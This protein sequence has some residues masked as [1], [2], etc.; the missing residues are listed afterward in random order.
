MLTLPARPERLRVLPSRLA[1]LERAGGGAGGG[2][3]L[4]WWWWWWRRRRQAGVAVIGSTIGAAAAADDEDARSDVER[5]V[6]AEGAR[7]HG[8]A[9]V[10]HFSSATLNATRVAGNEWAA[11]MVLDGSLQAL[12]PP[13]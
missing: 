11:V 6:D 13:A 2:A 3:E 7:E 8:R 1:L 5:L 4:W 12:S 9:A 10:T